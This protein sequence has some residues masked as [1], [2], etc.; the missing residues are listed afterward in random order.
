M[1]SWEIPR[2]LLLSAGVGML[3][4]GTKTKSLLCTG[5]GM[6]LLS[7]RTMLR[8]GIRNRSLDA[9][10][11]MLLRKTM[12]R[13]SLIRTVTGMLQMHSEMMSL[14][15]VV[16]IRL[17]AG[18]R[19]VLLKTRDGIPL[20]TARTIWL[21]VRVM[22]RNT[23]T[24]LLLL[25]T[26]SWL[27]TRILLRSTGARK[28][29]PS[30]RTW[31]LLLGDGKPVRLLSNWVRILWPTT[32][33]GTLLLETGAGTLL[34]VTRGLLLRM[35]HTGMSVLRTG[36]RTLLLSTGARVLLLSTEI[37]L[38]GNRALLLLS[39]TLRTLPKGLALGTAMTRP[40]R[41]GKE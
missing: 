10:I 23:R 24:L 20:L 31:T 8:T 13:I 39:W 18:T 1:L 40:S 11:E 34:L 27:A 9:E 5:A 19:A 14:S 6:L 7:T 38:L 25:K 41:G 2:A 17:T 28:R 22:L 3:L 12:T 15:T 33:T 21:N 16:W 30:S 29:L 4:W 37:L 32:R 36:T 26:S 35:M